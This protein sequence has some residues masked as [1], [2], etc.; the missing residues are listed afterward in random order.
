MSELR[1]CPFC[2]KEFRPSKY[3]PDQCV[4][5]AHSCQQKRR[6]AFH[7]AKVLQDPS[8]A[9]QCRESRRK[10]R[11]NN[12]PFLQEYRKSRR[13]ESARVAQEKQNERLKKLFALVES[14]AVFNLRDW[15]TEV[16]LV[17]GG[18]ITQA[19]KILR[20]AKLIILYSELSSSLPT[21]KM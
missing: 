3:H 17:C 18:D 1:T 14:S 6:S 9:E 10:W 5:S 21:T 15:S 19:D 11:A 12:K 13:L 8:Y 16:W 2:G 20:N 4:C 7:R